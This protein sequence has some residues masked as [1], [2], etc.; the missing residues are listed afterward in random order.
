MRLVLSV[1]I[2]LVLASVADAKSGNYWRRMATREGISDEV[3]EKYLAEAS[4]VDR[5]IAHVA[6][7]AKASRARMKASHSR[8]V[9][10][11][12]AMA[13]WVH[14]A[15]QP[16]LFYVP[17]VRVWPRIYTSDDYYPHHYYYDHLEEWP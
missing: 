5:A 12:A 16:K 14:Q 10:Y 6:S 17:V 15:T 7:D 9:G 8:A 4:R 2:V 13:S 1:L 3:K 11:S